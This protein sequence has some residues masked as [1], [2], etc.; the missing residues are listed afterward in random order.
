MKYHL[1]LVQ[2]MTV[3]CKDKS[4]TKWV[5]TKGAPEVVLANCHWLDR[6]RSG[7]LNAQLRNRLQNRAENMSREGYWH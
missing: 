3:I 1:I 5:F 4:G 7:N 2:K 6:G